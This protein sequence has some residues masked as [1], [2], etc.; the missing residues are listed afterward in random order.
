MLFISIPKSWRSPHSVGG[1][2]EGWHFS[3]R[4]N[5]GNEGMN[6]EEIRTA[7]LGFYEKR[8]KL[9]LLNSEL[10]EIIAN[11]ETCFIDD[12]EKISESYSLI[13]FELS[14]IESVISDTYSITASLPD[15]LGALSRIRKQVRI[16]NTRI[17]MLHNHVVLP[18]NN[19]KSTIKEHNSQ[20]KSIA[21][22]IIE[23]CNEACGYLDSIVNES[24]T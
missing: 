11:A 6:T 12:G 19:I 24:S 7:F 18:M 23:V 2:E 1:H 4:T 22:K 5:K 10:K 17:K 14:I 16:A 8:L 3:K 9:G 13:T 20:M 15:L 21:G